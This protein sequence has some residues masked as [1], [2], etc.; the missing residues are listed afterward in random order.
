MG[1]ADGRVVGGRYR[2]QTPLGRGGMGVVWRARDQLLHRDVAIKEVLL[3]PGPGAREHAVACERMQ[4]EARLAAGVRHASVV[5][6]FDVIDDGGRPWIVME[7]VDGQ[8]LET[9]VAEHGPLAPGQVARV[10]YDLLGALQAAHAAGV[11]H[12]DVK[13]ANV[14]LARDGRVVLTDFGIATWEGAAPLTQSGAFV[15]SPGYVAPEVA[16]GERPGP[17]SDLW[18]LGATLYLAVEGR[19]PF[20]GSTAMA[21]LAALLTSEPPPP[22]RA[23]PLTPALAALLQRDPGRR[24]TPAQLARL[25]TADPALGRHQPGPDFSPEL[26]CP[27]A[28]VPL[29]SAV[30][31]SDRG[32]PGAGPGNTSSSTGTVLLAVGL[33][34]LIL[35]VIGVLAY[36][37]HVRNDLLSGT[38]SQ[39]S[40][41]QAGG[42]QAGPAAPGRRGGR[43]LALPGAP[44]PVAHGPATLMPGDRRAGA[45]GLAPRLVIG[46]S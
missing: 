7:L 17:E 31:G 15:G 30:A 36:A 8:S 35:A 12:R 21:T 13:P 39:V 11:L 43:G 5:T 41:S 1:G 23:G 14:L 10:G 45:P 24:A 28:D 33:V 27:A 29:A 25:L 3:T 34:V 6:V 26:R 2:L 42:S 32:Q 20:E 37:R 16:R 4:R 9:V 19:P 22:R 38:A 44:G 46:E 18:S 40:G